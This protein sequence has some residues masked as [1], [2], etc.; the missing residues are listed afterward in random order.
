M[1]SR[2]LIGEG[3]SFVENVHTLPLED[4]GLELYR[5][6]SPAVAE[7]LV[8]RS[9]EDEIRRF[10][11]NDG[12]ERFVS[13][14]SANEW[15]KSKPHV[16][17]ALVQKAALAGVVWLSHTPR[18]EVDAE[19]TFA[20]RMYESQRGHGL[21]GALLEAALKDFETFARYEG[22]IWL[23]A[24]ETN[25]RALHFYEKHGY[26]RVSSSNGRVLMV[27]HGTRTT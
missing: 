26:E 6:W 8:E 4:K 16:A 18:P 11:P 24:D 20:I 19:Y 14:N 21:A 22:N 3:L 1:S 25:E 17:Y 9:Q 5:G 13:L 27:R 10:T 2:F 12:L 15:Y 23:E 7:Q